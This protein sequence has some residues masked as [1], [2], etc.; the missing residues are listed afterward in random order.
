MSQSTL[1][2]GLDYDQ[3]TAEKQR[4][5]NKQW[6]SIKSTEVDDNQLLKAPDQ[7][8]QRRGVGDNLVLLIPSMM[9]MIWDAIKN[10]KHHVM[11]I[12]GEM[13]LGKT[14]LGLWVLFRVYGDWELV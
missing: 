11:P 3:T 6:E 13:G 1:L 14:T 5:L 10:N 12:W 2:E 4:R 9:N 7:L 8:I